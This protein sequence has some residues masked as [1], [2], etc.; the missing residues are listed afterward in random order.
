[1]GNWESYHQIGKSLGISGEALQVN[2]QGIPTVKQGA[3]EY[4][5]FMDDSHKATW[6]PDSISNKHPCSSVWSYE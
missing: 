6:T 2:R 5:Y 1:M 4:D 3:V